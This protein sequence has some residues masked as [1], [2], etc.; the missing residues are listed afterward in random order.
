MALKK[1]MDVP[2]PPEFVE[3]IKN[4]EKNIMVID[5]IP[6]IPKEDKIEKEIKSLK[7]ENKKLQKDIIDVVKE[8][9]N[10]IT[11]K[12]GTVSIQYMLDEYRTITLGLTANISK[13]I[14]PEQI[15]EEIYLKL[16]QSLTN[17]IEKTVEESNT[18]EKRG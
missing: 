1:E 13:G 12:E 11:Y 8:N 2:N 7:R 4:E 18:N 17:I 14:S 15:H 9:S 5:G 6:V 16:I 10:I 3:E